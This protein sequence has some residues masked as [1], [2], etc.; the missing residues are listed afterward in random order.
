M[1]KTRYWNRKG[2]EISKEEYDK[3]ER[4]Q[5]QQ[6]PAYVSYV[7]ETIKNLNEDNY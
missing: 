7:K 5:M 2:K 6:E 1:I 3:A 4:E